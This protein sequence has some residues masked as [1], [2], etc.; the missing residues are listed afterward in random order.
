MQLLWLLVA[1]LAMVF[2]SLATAQ[3]KG[4]GKGKGKQETEWMPKI[5]G[6]P[7]NTAL[8]DL[9]A[10]VGSSAANCWFAGLPLNGIPKAERLTETSRLDETAKRAGGPGCF[11]PAFACALN[12][13]SRALPSTHIFATAS[14][15]TD[16]LVCKK[17]GR[18]GMGSCVDGRRRLR[19]R[20]RSTSIP[21][22]KRRG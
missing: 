8:L 14:L 20:T 21:C 4:K 15:Y 19:W 22:R 2:A 3:E 10:P 9:A 12:P 18:V 7:V 11:A 1:M 17:Y 13:T 16:R 6:V 5:G